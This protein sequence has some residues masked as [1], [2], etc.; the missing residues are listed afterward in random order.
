MRKGNDLSLILSRIKRQL[1]AEGMPET[2]VNEILIGAKETVSV[3]CPRIKKDVQ[4]R[5][6]EAMPRVGNGVR[7]IRTKAGFRVFTDA[8][9]R[10]MSAAAHATKPWTKT[11]LKKGKVF[12]D[13]CIKSAMAAFKG[14]EEQ[15]KKAWIDPT[16][17]GKD[18]SKIFGRSPS[19]IA[20]A[21]KGFGL[22]RREARIA[23]FQANR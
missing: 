5:I 12:K 20:Y 22:G 17:S 16:L 23:Y 10:R 8:S 14:K 21:A 11:G 4:N 2:K 3:P 19:Y 18:L 13:A 9:T 15:L 6:R 7:V 1:K